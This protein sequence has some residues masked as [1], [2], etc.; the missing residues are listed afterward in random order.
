MP[1]VSVI[2]PV[3]NVE[4]YLRQA[5]E[6]ILAQ[7]M[8]D[9]EIICVDDCST[10]ASRGILREYADKDNRISCILHSKNMS[11]SQGRKDGVLSSSGQYVMFLDP[12]D[13][14]EPNAF[15]VACKAIKEKGTD[16]VQFGT[17]IEN[18]VGLPEQVI[19]D[20][21]RF[22]RCQEG[23]IYNN[24]LNACFVGG[25]KRKLN[26]HVWNKIYKG[27]LCRKVFAAVEDGI[28]AYGQD[29]YSTFLVLYYAKSAAVIENNLYHYRFGSGP[30]GSKK[31]NIKQFTRICKQNLVLAAVKRF[32]AKLPDLEQRELIPSVEYIK[33]TYIN[34]TIDN[35]NK[36]L[37]N[38]WKIEDLQAICSSLVPG[39][40][41][42]VIA[43]FQEKLKESLPYKDIS[44]ARVDIKNQGADTNN[45][46]IVEV[47]DTDA[48]ITEPE[49]I[50]ENGRGH[51]IESSNGS[52]D[53]KLKCAGDGELLITLRGVNFITLDVNRLPIWIDYTKFVVDDK[54]IFDSVK[55]LWHDKVYKFTTEAEDGKVVTV[56]IEWVADFVSIG[57]GM[58]RRS[59]VECHSIKET[60]AL[61]EKLKRELADIRSGMSFRI[62]RIITYIPRKIL[63]KK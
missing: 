44:V 55:P 57:G 63:G 28:F 36:L 58:D 26:W 56:H 43:S 8:Q 49:F 16:L 17:I 34:S 22:L 48:I 1:K 51:V 18:C 9:F 13:Y 12:D 59:S 21:N 45:V 33:Q 40:T 47:S 27:D 31:L 3:Y 37:P 7:T 10:D 54:T 5:L 4:R 60:N 41:A 2:V 53:L 32:T 25:L 52:L 29:V 39:D 14:F 50:C 46:E 30:S 6:S 11:V 35:F 62:G 42:F 38:N 23:V 19:I 61:N 15:E 24:L 20:K